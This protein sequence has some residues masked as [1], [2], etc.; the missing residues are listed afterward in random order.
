MITLNT[1]VEG[2]SNPIPISGAA[3]DTVTAKRALSNMME[4]QGSSETLEST[5]GSLGMLL[6]IAVVLVG[7][8][9]YLLRFHIYL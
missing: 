8:I 4:Q 2:L 6:A 3:T 7:A 5:D 9:H 1:F